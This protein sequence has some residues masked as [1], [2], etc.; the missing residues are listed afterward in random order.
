MRA[1]KSHNLALSFSEEQAMLMD[2]AKALAAAESPRQRVRELMATESGYCESTWQQMVE[3]GWAGIALP[4]AVGGSGLG[5]GAL[6]PI[7]E[8]MG[9]QLLAGPL[10][11]SALAGQLLLRLGSD[12][13]QQR[14][15]A[16]IATGSKATIAHYESSDIGGSVDCELHA[17]AGDSLR[18]SG[19]KRFVADAASAD[20]I[21][22][23]ARLQG[24]MRVV[25]VEAERLVDRINAH[26]PVDETRRAARLQLDG[27]E[28]PRDAVLDAA[29]ASAAL[30]D[31]QLLGALLVA[32]ES[33]GAS[34]ACLDVIV[35]YLKT[36]TQ[37]GRQIG[38][39]QALKHPAVDILQGVD[40]ARSL[41]YHAASLL[42]ENGQVLTEDMRI[43]CHMA[44]VQAGDV[45]CYAGDRAVQFHGGLGFTWDCDAQLFNRRAQ[46]AAQQFGDSRWHR[47]RLAEL[48]L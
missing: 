26:R 43:A 17:A 10:L 4:E 3:L 25:V 37:F 6:V 44:K 31:V 29:D 13:Q 24:D 19:S 40:A 14:W 36:R 11:S 9:R 47:A 15:L 20:L 2:S 22:I 46:W 12:A 5:M 42:V 35:D 7:V 32:A 1:M 39:Y 45:L 34:A 27:L 23:S 16:P 18:F 30:A 41:V 21:L 28:V 8:A 48:M 38:S 33:A